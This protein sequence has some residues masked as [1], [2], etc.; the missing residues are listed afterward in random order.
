MSKPQT[1]ESFWSRVDKSAGPDACWE[2]VGS[3]NSNGYGNT[4]W[5]GKLY[6]A[7]RVAAWL[8]G[9]VPTPSAPVSSREPTHVLHRCDNR[10]CCNPAHFFLGTFSDNM[11][12]AYK[13]RRKSQPKG[14]Q[15]VNA[16]L[17]AEQVAEIRR[18][19]EMGALQVPL[20]TEFGVSQRTISLVVRKETYK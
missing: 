19:Y 10:K 1:P 9:L 11:H 2:W 15:H 14:E 3:L 4:S 18:R 12:D 13:K 16:K 6:T 17:T 20:A 5:H 7:H 8:S